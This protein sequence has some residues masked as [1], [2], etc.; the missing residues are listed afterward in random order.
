M[1][2][3]LLKLLLLQALSCFCLW[4]TAGAQTAVPLSD[5]IDQHIFSFKEIY[6]LEDTTGRYDIKKVLTPQIAA[7]FKTSPISTPVAKNSKSYYWYRI[8]VQ[9]NLQ[10]KNNWLLEFFD[11]T[12]NDITFYA[13]GK[14]GDYLATHMGADRPFG[15][16]LFQHKNFSVNL[17]NTTAKESTYYIRIK[18][19]QPANVIVVLRS[20]SWFIHY[21]LDEYF[22]FGI[23]YG[24]IIVFSLYNLVMFFA[25]RQIQYLYYIM[26]NLSIGLF[27]MCTDGIAYQYIWPNASGWNQYAYGVALY[28]S[29]LFG[30]LFT[31]KLLYVKSKAGRLHKVIWGVIILRT[32]FFLACLF[33]NKSW[34]T[35]KIIEFVP[36]TLAF[37]TGCRIMYNGYRPARFFVIGYSFLL[38]GFMIKVLIA[39]NVDWLPF[40]PVTHYSM[41]VCFIME[42]SFISFAIG[43]KVRLLKKKKEKAQRNT[44]RQLQQN[45]ELKDNLNRTLEIQVTERTREVTEQ[46]MLIKH[47]YEELKQVNYLLEEQA[48]EISR[49]NVLLEKDNIILQTNIEKVTHDRVMSADLDFEEFS[50]IYPDREACYKFLADLKWQHGYTC[51]K[52]NNTQYKTGHLPFSRRCSKCG[53][54]ESAIAYTVLQNTRFPVNKAFYMIFLL[55]STKGKISTHKISEQLTIRQ[56]TCWAF[57]SRIKKVMESKKKELRNAGKMGWSKLLMDNSGT[58]A[59]E[60]VIN[61]SATE[62]IQ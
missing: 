7:Q 17:L 9:N 11:Q 39:L 56:S 18:S 35:F 57:S 53:Y 62:E 61:L 22:F 14:N 50:T 15:Q 25:M 16:R 10:S 30:L 12:I 51:R 38:V 32:V 48:K 26:Y 21:A 36:L 40:G 20:V 45:E 27:E 41:S 19:H 34:F 52:C 4:F 13:P 3:L 43:D 49:M 1:K 60:Q 44:I 31:Q 54:D 5:H 42:M 28:L 55:Y 23:F 46:S 29:S 2:K 8:T 47:Q 6:T 33:I 58:M 59:D 37:V 24:M